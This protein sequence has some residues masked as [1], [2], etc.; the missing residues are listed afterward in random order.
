MR[1]KTVLVGV[2]AAVGALV[3]YAA[4]FAPARSERRH[5]GEQVAAAES[6]ERQL[7]A[8]RLRLRRLEAGQGVQRAQVEWL[9]RLVPP[10]PDVAGFLLGAN[11]AAA[12]SGVEWLSVAP[13]AVVAGVGGGPST[14]GVS[15][16]V[17]AGFFAFV[18]YLR[19]LEG[20]GRLVVVDSLQLSASGGP[21][22][23]ARLRATV[24]ARI[25]TTA[26]AARTPGSPAPA[27]TNGGGG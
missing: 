20:M 21:A 5:L 25:F 15:I 2:A 8:T 11:D 16:G 9:Q 17:N 12:R 10:E 14:I 19:R 26:P 3:W 27:P 18:D 23:P 4:L 13:A 22:G 1:R 6:Q 24:S 7:H